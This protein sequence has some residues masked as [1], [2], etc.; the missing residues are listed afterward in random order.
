E[1][2]SELFVL[3]IQPFEDID[4]KI[5]PERASGRRKAAFDVGVSNKAN[6]PVLV[7]L[8]GVEPENAC[9][10]RFTEPQREIEPGETRTPRMTVRPP[11]QIW[12][13]RPLERRFDL[14]LL[15]GEAAEAMPE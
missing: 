9:D 6:A 8:E 5:K 2:A 4:A 13:G 12:I 7:G 1:V 15:T 11:K 10:F 14:K 3:G